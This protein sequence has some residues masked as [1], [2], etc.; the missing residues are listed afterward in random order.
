MSKIELYTYQ[1]VVE[2][3]V[4]AD[5]V[6]VMLDLGFGT[7]K[8]VRC[9]LLDL[10]APEKG[11]ELGNRITEDLKS[12]V[13]SACLVYSKKLDRYGRSLAN[14]KIADFDLATYI[15]A[16]YPETRTASGYNINS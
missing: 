3:I 11:S 13:R 8:L 15:K 14:I 16:K 5:T 10:H 6:M 2:R 4:D 7:F 9:R 12:F 1:G